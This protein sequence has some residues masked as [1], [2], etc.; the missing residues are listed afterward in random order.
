MAENNIVEELLREYYAQQR[1]ITGYIYSATRDYHA[2]QDIF[3]EV[4]I[5]VT[6]KADT[7]DRS[8][9][10]LPWF[11]G[12]ARFQVLSWMRANGKKPT[13]VSFDVL[14]ECFGEMD[15]AFTRTTEESMRERALK[16]CIEKLPPKQRSII[17]LRYRQMLSCDHIAE[18]VSQS[19]QSIYSIVKRLKRSLRDCVSAR[20]EQEMS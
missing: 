8:R 9:P 15:P 4:A 1:M 7:F 16:T 17:D 18:S 20:M 12:I 6:R 14:D 2:T 3:Q 19:I 13:H 5:A 10:P 11:F